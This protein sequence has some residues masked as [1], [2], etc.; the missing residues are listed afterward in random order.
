MC[1]GNIQAAAAKLKIAP[2]T[3]YQKLTSGK[4]K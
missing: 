3:I 2:S 4:Q 1:N